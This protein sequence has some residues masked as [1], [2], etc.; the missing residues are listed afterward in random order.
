[1]A[2]NQQCESRRRLR[3]GQ[4]APSP[5]PPP[6]AEPRQAIRSR[7]PRCVQPHRGVTPASALTPVLCC[8]VLCCAWDGLRDPTQT[9]SSRSTRNRRTTLGRPAVATRVRRCTRLAGPSRGTTRRRCNKVR[10]TRASKSVPL[11]SAPWSPRERNTPERVLTWYIPPLPVDVVPPAFPPP[12]PPSRCTTASSRTCSPT[13]SCNNRGIPVPV[14]ALAA[15][16]AV[17]VRSSVSRRHSRPASPSLASRAGGPVSACRCTMNQS[18]TRTSLC[19]DS[20][21]SSSPLPLA[22]CSRSLSERRP[23]QVSS[24][25]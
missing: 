15:W 25:A 20:P 24:G 4:S 13:S 12:P 5:Q 8:V 2:Y 17:Q 18:L 23:L 6:G 21:L 14:A 10:P 9:V 22:D 16:P 3:A 11:P 1:M 7:P 19:S